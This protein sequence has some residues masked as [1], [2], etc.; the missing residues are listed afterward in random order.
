MTIPKIKF[1]LGIV[2]CLIGTAEF[3]WNLKNG[4][5]ITVR[6]LLSVIVGASLIAHSR[7]SKL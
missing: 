3:L 1:I 7:S 2:G 5:G 6:P 4:A